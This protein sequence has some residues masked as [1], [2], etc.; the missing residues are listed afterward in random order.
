MNDMKG[1]CPNPQEHL[2]HFAHLLHHRKETF[3]L[4][5]NT[6][7]YIYMHAVLNFTLTWFNENH[8]EEIKY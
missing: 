4:K 1:Y 8:F 2:E 7:I 5:K 6:L 3:F